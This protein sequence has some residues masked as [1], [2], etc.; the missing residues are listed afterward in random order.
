MNEELKKL[1]MDF[2]EVTDTP[3]PFKDRKFERISKSS[4]KKPEYVVVQ[5]LRNNRTVEWKLSKIVSGNIIV[6]NNKGHELNPKDTWVKGKNTWYIVREKDSKPVSVR[7]K[8]IGHNTDDGPVLMKMVL[9]AMMKKEAEK[10]N[11]KLIGILIGA[12]LLGLILWAVLG[13]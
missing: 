9:G 2:A 6:I 8:P 4:K 7:D 3:K 10:V 12:V 11:K 1:K 13:R 5:Y